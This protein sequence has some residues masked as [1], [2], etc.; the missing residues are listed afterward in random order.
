MSFYTNNRNSTC[1]P[2]PI[3]GNPLNGLCEK[4]C[5][6]TTKVFDSAMKQLPLNGLQQNVD[7][8]G[9]EPTLPITYI[10]AVNDPENP[11]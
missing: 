7:F 11:S 1:C 5:I 10:G 4:V 3:N 6:R 2:G 9:T 8:G